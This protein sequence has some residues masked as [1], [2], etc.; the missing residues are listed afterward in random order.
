VKASVLA[1]VSLL[2]IVA[3]MPVPAQTTYPIPL[4]NTPLV[5]AATAPGGH[6][7]VLTVNGNGFTPKS[8]VR[9]NGRVRKT[10]FVTN[11]QLTAKILSSDIA[12]ASAAVVTVSNPGDHQ[13]N[14]V[15]FQVTTPEQNITM[16]VIRTRFSGYATAADLNGD[17]I[18]DLIV[19]QSSTLLIALG[20]GGDTFGQPQVFSFSFPI[21]SVT[22]GDFDGDGKPDIA[23]V[24]DGVKILYNN[25]DGTFGHIRTVTDKIFSSLA[26]AD[27]DGNGRLDLLGT[28]QSDPG[29]VF[30]MLQN[31][32]GSFKT[33]VP[34]LVGKD[35]IS[36]AVGDFNRDDIADLA[37]LNSADDSISILLGNGD[38]T[39]Q[40]QTIYSAG[41]AG[42]FPDPVLVADLNGDGKLDL[43]RAAA[44]FTAGVGV[45]LGNGDGTFQPVHDYGSSSYGLVIGDFNGD[46]I[47]DLA[48]GLNGTGTG[49][50]LGKGDGSFPTLDNFDAGDLGFDVSAADFGNASF[51]S[52]GRLD[53]AA[54]TN[55]GVILL[56]Q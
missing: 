55:H 36:V 45:L 18:P 16:H 48:M 6:G 21:S 40:P 46:G 51:S 20:R 17:R 41:S 52:N 47:L 2:L 37:V 3:P 39:F 38:G 29:Y 10:T 30:V 35:P 33:P 53:L 7:F 28:Q 32:N 13:S 27:L 15:G 24:A 23:L 43:V 14:P 1:I 8:L 34:H 22:V 50:L 44:L 56:V 31:S 42:D 12:A 49:I 19:A 9:W 26:A 25:G 4:L 54:T 11:T 5:P